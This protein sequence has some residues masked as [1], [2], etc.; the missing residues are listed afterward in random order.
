MPLPLKIARAHMHI[1][2]GAPKE[3]KE[4]NE[5]EIF[6][7]LV[8]R[9]PI[10]HHPETFGRSA[11]DIKNQMCDTFSEVSA[12][13]NVFTKQVVMEI[14]SQR[15]K[16]QGYK[17]VWEAKDFTLTRIAQD[18]YLLTYF[19]IQNKSYKKINLLAQIKG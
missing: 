13:G 8:S 7:E 6:E 19:L 14:L 17:D 9:E 10:F 18:N 5:S 15:Y 3:D 1:K 12:S 2:S 11:Q 4:L 16:D